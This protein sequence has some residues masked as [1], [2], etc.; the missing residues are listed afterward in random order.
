MKKSVSLILIVTMLFMPVLA[1]CSSKTTDQPATT[2][3]KGSSQELEATAKPEEP[4]NEAKEDKTDN[5][6]EMLYKEAPMLQ[7]KGLPPVTDRLPREPKIVNEMPHDYQKLE[8]GQYGGTLRTARTGIGY[9]AECTNGNMEWLLNTPGILGEEITPNILKGYEVSDDEKEFTFYMREGLK[10]SDGEPVTSEDVAFTVNDVIFNEEITSVFPNWLRS[11]DKPDGS[12]VQFEVVDEYTFKMKF[13]EPYGGFLMRL[14]IQGW[15]CYN[16]L[17][18][19]KHYLMDFHAKYTPMEKLEQLIEE[20]SFEKGEWHNLFNSKDMSAWESIQPKAVGFPVLSPWMLV[21]LNEV[22]AVYERNPYYFKI[23]SAGN[24]LP[25]IDRLESYLVQ[26]TEMFNMKIIAGEIDFA[27]EIP[28]LAKMPLFKE[29]EEKGGYIAHTFPMQVTPTDIHLNLTFEDPVWREVVR[30]V[31][32][33]KALNMAIERQELIDS[34]YFGYAKPSGIVDSTYNLEEGN[35][36][37]DE[38]GMTKGAD[39]FRVGPDGKKFSI[40]FEISPSVPDMI[41]LGELVVEMWKQ[42]GLDVTMKQID[43]GLWGTRNSANQLQAT[44]MWTHTPLWY[45][46]DIGQGIWANLWNR[47]MVTDGKEGEEPPEEYKKLHESMTKVL[48]N[49]PDVARKAYYDEVLKSI[50]DN[51]WYFVHLQEVQQPV[52]A[53][54]KLGNI[55]EKGVALS[56]ALALETYYFKQ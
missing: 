8:A 48:T 47:W 45:S 12:P 26:D 44:M 38:M 15:M 34:V 18:K 11:G 53:N 17:L 4:E 49:S 2:P 16:V 54:A 52:I 14:A 20:A 5:T 1:G 21:E 35:R 55:P 46:G 3:T 37:L 43:S 42:L 40:P 51:V 22:K 36:L 41:P 56:T 9:D 27:R 23:D 10:W 29:N 6:K 25:Y 28:S 30:D 39:G 50:H 7:G 33:R 32:F 24:Q 19:P 31:R 13:D